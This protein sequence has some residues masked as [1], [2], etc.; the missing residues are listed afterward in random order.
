MDVAIS[1]KVGHVLLAFVLVNESGSKFPLSELHPEN[2]QNYLIKLIELQKNIFPRGNCNN[3]QLDFM[4]CTA[5]IC[6]L[7]SRTN[8][9]FTANLGDSM[10]MHYHSDRK[11]KSHVK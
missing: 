9:V 4:G 2:F 3:I 11:N 10:T 8:K 6:Y 7:Q 1:S 5:N